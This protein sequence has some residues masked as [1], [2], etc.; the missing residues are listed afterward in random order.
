MQNAILQ[1]FF[2]QVLQKL[3][4]YFLKVFTDGLVCNKT[5]SYENSDSQLYQN[6]FLLILKNT[7]MSEISGMDWVQQIKMDYAQNVK[8]DSEMAK[9]RPSQNYTGCV[10][11]FHSSTIPGI[12][13]N[14][15]KTAKF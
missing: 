9:K 14:F 8:K 12:C 7:K 1:Y 2:N 6:Y 11:P 15:I 5:L 3:L 13:S 10:S 4:Q